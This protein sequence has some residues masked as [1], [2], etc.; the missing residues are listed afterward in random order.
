[1]LLLLETALTVAAILVSLRAPRLGSHWLERI[2]E[3]FRRIGRKRA[4]SVLIVAAAAMG[5]RAVVL[6]VFPVPVPQVDDEFSHLLLAD[7]LLHGRL[8]NPT[9]S[10]WKHFETLEVNMLP[11]YASVYPPVQ[12]IFLAAGRLLAGHPFVGVM[13]SV[14]VM[15]GVICW[16]LQGWLSAEWAFL[17][18]LLAVMR[19]AVFSYWADGYMGGAPSAIGG[20][21]ALGALPRLKRDL[22]TRDGVI[23]AIGLSVLANSRPYEGSVLSLLIALSLVYWFSRRSGAALGAVGRGLVVPLFL[24]AILTGLAMGYYFWRLTGSPLRTP[25]QV[26]W[27]TYGMMPKFVWQPLRVQQ[28]MALRHD[29]LKDFYYV[30][31]YDAYANIHTITGLVGAW[32][33]RAVED[34]AFY[35]GPILTLPLIAVL[36]TAPYGFRWKQLDPN[37]R[38]L[39]LA[40]VIIGMAI[41]LEVFSYP[42][43]AAPITCVLIA[44]VLLA[45]RSLRSHVHHNRPFGLALTRAIPV[46]SI[47]MLALRAVA[48]PL[49]IPM[50]T[51]ILCTVYD[52]PRE[53]IPSYQAEM[54]LEGMPGKHLIIV[55]YPTGSQAWMGWVHNGAD[56]DH[57]KVVRAW[58][59]G[60]EKNRELVEYFKSRQVWYV[61]SGD[62][63]PVLRPYVE[64]TGR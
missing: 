55:H 20:A 50:R 52:A 58:D 64:E 53:N 2:E 33:V 41:A 27:E 24:V 15:C 35:L 22:R 13:L 12:G 6:P 23:L 49:H 30:W 25:Y 62:K 60:K 17:G 10:L 31:E 28:A 14:A 11:T 43:Y 59:M 34:W 44:L 57:S 42:H 45:M 47:F 63:V 46:I 56:I 61:N 38:F 8:T 40:A 4:L 29:A 51:N 1:M 39:I 54:G 7:T 18:G 37:T 36:A 5:A 16:M 32:V 3:W 21:L 26:N 48:L 19:F 9:P